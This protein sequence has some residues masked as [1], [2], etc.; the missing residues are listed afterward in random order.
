MCVGCQAQMSSAQPTQKW[1]VISYIDGYNLYF[2]LRDKV[3]VRGPNNTQP[4]V[5]WRKYM[6]LDVVRL[7]EVLLRKDQVL[8]RTKYFTSRI[9]GKP[10]SEMRQGLFLDAISILPNIEFYWGTFQ[11]DPKECRKC[12]GTAFHPQE[13]KTDVNI[14]TQ[15][16][17]DA[18]HN[19]FDT[20]RFSA[21]MQKV[22]TASYRIG[23][24]KFKMC[25]MPQKIKLPS[26]IEI[27]CPSKWT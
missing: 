13:K 26:G 9:R 22:A 19:N 1:R 16:L 5:H 17:N 3:R 4:N 25:L 7:S 2:G 12:G 21:E 24:D 15:M 10:Q 8:I 14:A 20:A 18:I 6:W 11:P 27:S 23:E